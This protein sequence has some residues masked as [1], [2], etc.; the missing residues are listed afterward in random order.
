MSLQSLLWDFSSYAFDIKVHARKCAILL[1][2]WACECVE[3][4]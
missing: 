1:I 2:Q 3:L 4:G